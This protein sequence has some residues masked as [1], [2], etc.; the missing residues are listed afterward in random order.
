MRY[1]SRHCGEGRTLLC[2]V[3]ASHFLALLAEQWQPP[4]DMLLSFHTLESSP[5]ADLP[6]QTGK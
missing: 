4:S 6:N 5:A 3:Q 2:G 1:L